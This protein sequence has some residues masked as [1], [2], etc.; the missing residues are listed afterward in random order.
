MNSKPENEIEKKK[1]PNRKR[2]EIENMQKK[3][4]DKNFRGGNAKI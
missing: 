2:K 3:L 4:G 1:S